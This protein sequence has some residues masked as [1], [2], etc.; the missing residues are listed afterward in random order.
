M[1]SRSAGARPDAALFRRRRVMV[2][3]VLLFVVAVV[4]TVWTRMSGLVGS[5]D[6]EGIAPAQ[7]SVS[8]STPP[9][10]ASSS[11]GSS[12]SAGAVANCEAS[13]LVVV[14]KTDKTNY[15]AG[16]LPSFTIT[17]TNSGDVACSVDVGSSQ[18]RLVVTS[19]ETTIWRSDDCATGSK[20]T[21][22]YW[23]Y[24]KVVQ[25]GETL[26]SVAVEW[27]RVFSDASDCK[28]SPAAVNGGGAAYWLTAYVGDVRSSDDNRKQFFLQ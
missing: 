21:D 25:P 1:T 11:A 10:G 27:D 16:K 20:K 18:L 17:L 9:E 5:E 8:A 26:E 15:A 22:K 24:V 6:A 12:A 28:A 23:N 4:L 7:T 14:A 13:A 19:G 3:G 2:F